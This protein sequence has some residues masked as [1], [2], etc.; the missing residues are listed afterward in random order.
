MVGR[1]D[2]ALRRLGLRRAGR[3]DLPDFLGI[4]V[5][6]AGTTW[7]HANL[8]A[9]PE[10]HLPP[11]KELHHF[12]WCEC[13]TLAGYASHFAGAAGR[14][15]GEIT[16]GYSALAPRHIRFVA[17]LVP[18]CRLLLLLRDPV[19]RAWSQAMM[20]LARK[21]GRRPADVPVDEVLHHL[22]SRGA[23]RRGEYARIITDWRAAFSTEQL[24]IGTLDDVGE[25]PVE[26]LGEVFAHL[27]VD[28]DP[29]W[30]R[31]PHDSIQNPGGG[32]P[33]PPEVRAELAPLYRQE[34]GRLEQLVG[35]RIA[36]WSV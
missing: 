17:R 23:R 29:D 14:V 1:S 9:H 18:R 21:R 16:P 7:L 36:R 2:Q 33:V 20:D 30:S 19:E 13:W 25:R 6:K 11:E 10:L 26:V 12:D 4:G 27:G 28:P 24:W 3:L 32:E 8:S 22:R 31:L 34:L 5:P 15:R 35:H